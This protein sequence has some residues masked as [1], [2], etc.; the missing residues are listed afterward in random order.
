M[1]E[2]AVWIAIT[3]WLI[4]NAF[5]L[6]WFLTRAAWWLGLFAALSI[7]AGIVSLARIVSKQAGSDNGQAI[8]RYSDDGERWWDPATGTWYRCSATLQEHCEIVAAQVGTYWRRT[9]LARLF[10]MGVILRYRLT[11]VC[12]G[13]PQRERYAVATAEFP[14]EAR[15]GITLDHLDP[16]QAAHDEYNLGELR[17]WAEDAVDYL[18]HVLT[19]SGW[20]PNGQA[21]V[22]WYATRYTRRAVLWNEP[23]AATRMAESG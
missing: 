2:D 22:H 4:V 7:G 15:H 16:A 20:Q 6:I 8:G 14:M 12:D 10:M 18:D 13:N 11:A 1:N 19:D 5:R 21:T 9:A 17:R 23:I 3:R